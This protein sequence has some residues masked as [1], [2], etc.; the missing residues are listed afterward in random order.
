MGS[1]Y[2][3]ENTVTDRMNNDMDKIFTCKRPLPQENKE[4][5]PFKAAI[6]WSV[7]FLYGNGIYIKKYCLIL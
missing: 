4:H 5:N 1:T 3:L 7:G 2:T 6:F